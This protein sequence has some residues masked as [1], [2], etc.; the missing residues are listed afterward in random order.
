MATR[1][2]IIVAN[3][4]QIVCKHVVRADSEDAAFERVQ[5]AYDKDQRNLSFKLKK[6]LKGAS[7]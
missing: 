1:Y 6:T 3:G 2:E 7:E 4:S 5:S